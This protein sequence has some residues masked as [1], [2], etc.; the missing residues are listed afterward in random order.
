MKNIQKWEDGKEQYILNNGLMLV[1]ADVGEFGIHYAIYVDRDEDF[2]YNWIKI[3]QD[4]Y[5]DENAF[6]IFKD[7]KRVGGVVIEPNYSSHFFVESP[8]VLDKFSI[9]SELNKALMQ[10][11]DKNKSIYLYLIDSK[12]VEVYNRLGYRKRFIRRTMIR[13]TEIFEDIQWREDLV[14]KAPAIEDAGEIGK[15]LHK[16]YKGGIQYE[17]FCNNTEED[18]IENTKMFLER[19]IATNSLHASTLVYDKNT[20]ELVAVCLAGK[21]KEDDYEFSKI[22]EVAVI[23]AYRRQG[24]AENLIKRTLTILKDISPATKLDVSVGNAAEGL[25][26]KMGFFPGVQMVAMHKKF[27]W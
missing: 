1:R 27:Q 20:V 26:Y 23:P 14:I 3:S 4:P 10:W 8:Y 17:E 5:Y 9:I 18:E 15:A 12:D 13:P 24:I 11:S 6:W 19:Y 7:N 2:K 25:Y 21:N 16:A 22:N